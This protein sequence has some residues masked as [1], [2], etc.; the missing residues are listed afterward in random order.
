MPQHED[1][2]EK[3]RARRAAQEAKRKAQQRRMKRML[4]LACVVLALCTAGLVYLIASA[5]PGSESVAVQPEKPVETKA[6]ENKPAA[7]AFQDPKTVIHIKAA[8]DLNI[9]DKV[10]VT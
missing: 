6:P 4:I 1:G 7:L 8:G 3:R 10:V 2:M 9:T 5:E